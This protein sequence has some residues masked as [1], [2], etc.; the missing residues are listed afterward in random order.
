[1]PI[2]HAR[3]ALLA[4]VYPVAYDFSDGAQTSQVGRQQVL[5]GLLAFQ[6]HNADMMEARAPDS[7]MML[8]YFDDVDAIIGGKKA[9]VKAAQRYLPM[10]SGEDETTYTTRLKYTKF[11]NVF[12]DICEGLAAKPFEEEVSLVNGD[13]DAT[14]P[15]AIAQFIENVDGAGNS[16][17]QFAG[18]TFFNA[19]ANAIDWIFVDFPPADPSVRTVADAKAAGRTPFWS[20]VLGRNVLEARV[21][22][23]EGRETLTY[24]R[25]FE[26]S[27]PRDRVRVIERDPVSAV[28]TWKLFE[29]SS[30]TS[31]DGKTQYVPID[32][33]DFNIPIIPLVPFATGRRDGRT[34][35]YFPALSDAADLQVTLYVNESG[36]EWTKALSAYPM[37]AGN[38]VSPQLSTDGK[39]PLKLAVGPG[40]VL[41]TGNAAEGR[42]HGSWAYVQPDAQ[43]FTALEASNSTTIQ[44]LRE[45]GRQPLTAQSG[46]ITV[47]TAAFAAGKAKSA[48]QAWALG[49]KNALENALAI[50]CMFTNTKYTPKVKVFTE[51]DTA[52]DNIDELPALGTAVSGK[53][54][55]EQTYREELARRGVLG[56]EYNEERETARLLAEAPA[57]IGAVDPVTGLQLPPAAKIGPDG[58]PL[59][60]APAPRNVPP[61]PTPTNPKDKVS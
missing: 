49:L 56:P 23:I 7:A 15:D 58:K 37:L 29:K 41:Y 42:T 39:T 9:M 30:T 14:P 20:H 43:L 47:I 52:S 33:G 61:K 11:T 22:M 54:I 18:A 27:S 40:V 57:D 10:F 44:N 45:L 35:R 6:T 1:M 13:D 4:S 24:I 28:I 53:I 5:D 12:R 50:T 16:I 26:P 25:I 38:G 59:P 2:I 34:F 55:S 17:T 19:V 3:T 60:P 31:P 48:V 51:F 32:Q 21:T 8:D 36:L 46:N